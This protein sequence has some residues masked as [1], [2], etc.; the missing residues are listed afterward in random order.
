[1]QE[2]LRGTSQQIVLA[3]LGEHDDWQ[4]GKTKIFLKVVQSIFFYTLKENV[5]CYNVDVWILSMVH[6]DNLSVALYCYVEAQQT[7][8]GSR[9]TLWTPQ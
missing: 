2:D 6:L 9:K 3:R 8:N 7:R 4:I 5:C 1:M